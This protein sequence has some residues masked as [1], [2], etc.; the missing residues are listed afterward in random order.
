MPNTTF[1]LQ[2]Q[3]K[4]AHTHL[5]LPNLQVEAWF[6]HQQKED[7]RLG[8]AQTDEAGACRITFEWDDVVILSQQRTLYFK[9]YRGERMIWNTFGKQSLW[10]MDKEEI[11]VELTIKRKSLAPK[12]P[13]EHIQ[14]YLSIKDLPQETP[15]QKTFVEDRLN[16]ALEQYLKRNIAPGIKE[17]A[18][19]IEALDLHFEDHLTTP[20]GQL[21]ESIVLPELQSQED[22]WKQIEARSTGRN[23]VDIRKTVE[24][25]LQ[26]DKPLRKNIHF[27]SEAQL[28]QTQ[29]AARISGL[30][31]GKTE[32]L[33]E[34]NIVAGSASNM[35]LKK[36]EE[37]GLLTS[38]E[39]QA[40]V[41]TFSLIRF[42]GGNLSLTETL[43]QNH[44]SITDLVSLERGDWIQLVEQSDEPTP[45]GEDVEDYARQLQRSVNRAYPTP[46]LLHRF[47]NTLNDDL[48]QTIIKGGNHN[49]VARGRNDRP[50]ALEALGNRYRYLGVPEILTSEALSG[51][52]R[53]TQVENAI[54]HLAAFYQNNPQAELR[55]A[56]FFGTE[57]R[58][59]PFVWEGIPEPARGPYKSN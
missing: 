1:Y 12:I 54:A 8:N 24:D 18:A 31:V 55:T 34:N 6:H 11:E 22:V 25:Y 4:D 56:R 33:F 32:I 16:Q 21:I 27:H 58:R 10:L 41:N 30:S 44:G 51:E 45:N 47:S 43:F 17:V 13:Y 20:I 9:V 49:E 59:T 26:L 46:F 23:G 28:M 3:V 52:E 57:E 7:E 37:E 40:L 15:E 14:F 5:P 38:G 2:I 50:D 29:L 42:T 39:K 35:R 48:R 36:L 53:L 19:A